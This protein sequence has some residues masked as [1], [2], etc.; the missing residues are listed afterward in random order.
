MSP[1]KGSSH[2]PGPGERMHNGSHT[3]AQVQAGCGAKVPASSPQPEYAVLTQVYSTLHT[4]REETS[5]SNPDYF[6]TTPHNNE[7]IEVNSM[8]LHWVC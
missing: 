3:Q 5:I 7:T 2:S 8:L 4:T 6:Y 1:T